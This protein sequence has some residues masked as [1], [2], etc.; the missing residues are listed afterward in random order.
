MSAILNRR[1]VKPGNKPDLNVIDFKNLRLHV[2]HSV[3]DLPANGR[4]IKQ[5]ATG[6]VATIIAGEER[7]CTWISSSNCCSPLLTC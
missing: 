7:T 4:R 6:F 2:P 3:F 1:V 5:R